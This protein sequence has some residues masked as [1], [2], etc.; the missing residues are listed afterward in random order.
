MDFVVLRGELSGWLRVGSGGVDVFPVGL[1][2]SEDVGGVFE[3]ACVAAVVEG[4][5]GVDEGVEG[6]FLADG[7]EVWRRR[8]GLCWEVGEEG[9]LG[10]VPELV[11]EPVAGFWLA[12]PWLGGA[13]VVEVEVE[14]S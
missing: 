14:V 12:E 13:D 6:G 4:A 2:L 1:G 10:L 3:G 8:A 9:G 5:L 7:L 11:G